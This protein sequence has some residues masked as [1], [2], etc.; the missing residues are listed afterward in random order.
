[1][2]KVP[3]QRASDTGTCHQRLAELVVPMYGRFAAQLGAG[4]RPIQGVAC[5]SQG[6]SLREK[7]SYCGRPSCCRP[8]YFNYCTSS[9][10]STE[11]ANEA[12]S[13]IDTKT[14]NIKKN[15]AEKGSDS[16]YG[17]DLTNAAIGY[18]NKTSKVACQTLS[19]GRK[20]VNFFSHKEHTD[21]VLKKSRATLASQF[22]HF[23]LFILT[24][25][26]LNKFR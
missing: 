21:F 3:C 14:I 2:R 23:S 1:M 19:F 8:D 12:T 20:T 16:K 15:I 6:A 22:G 24:Y 13:C 25:K 18:R 5:K 11:N 4:Q 17:N 7:V 10:T 26:P 9:T